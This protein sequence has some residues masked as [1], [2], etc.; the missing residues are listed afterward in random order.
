MRALAFEL[1]FTLEKE[2]KK[3]SEP[4]SGGDASF[5]RSKRLPFKPQPEQYLEVEHVAD[6]LG[7][8]SEQVVELLK[9]GHFSAWYPPSLEPPRWL[10]SASSVLDWLRSQNP[11]R[12]RPRRR[13]GDLGVDTG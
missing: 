6:I 2:M 3:K 11:G 4:S 10:I 12:G 7:C 13:V 9:A 8:R 1:T 5:N